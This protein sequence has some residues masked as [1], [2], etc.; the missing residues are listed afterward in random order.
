MNNEEWYKLRTPAEHRS[1]QIREAAYF[2]SLH[3]KEENREPDPDCDW[4]DAEWVYNNLS[5]YSEV[6]RVAAKA[7]IEA[8]AISTSIAFHDS[9]GLDWNPLIQSRFYIIMLDRL[10]PRLLDVCTMSAAV[11]S[12]TFGG[13]M[14]VLVTRMRCVDFT[15]L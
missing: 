12:K 1:A 6:K 15:R 3:R 5:V 10:R 13:L 7:V 8:G 2:I 11:K 9:V 14:D 4:H